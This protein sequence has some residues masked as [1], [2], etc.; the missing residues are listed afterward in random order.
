[1]YEAILNLN[2]KTFTGTLTFLT[3]K[4]IQNA[5]IKEFN[6]SLTIE[7]IFKSIGEDD[8]EVI[9]TLLIESTQSNLIDDFIESDLLEKFENIYKYINDL[10]TKCMPLSSLKKDNNDFE[11]IPNFD[12]KLKDWEFGWMEYMWNTTLKRENFWNITPYNFFEQMDI[13]KKINNIKDNS[14]VEEL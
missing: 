6:R 10:L 3:L 12:E 2:N 14:N 8:M 11:D 4:K 9:T 1:M 7:N 13:Y 5:L